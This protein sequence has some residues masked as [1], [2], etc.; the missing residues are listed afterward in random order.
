MDEV[1]VIEFATYDVTNVHSLAIVFMVVMTGLTIMPNRS[2]AAI[3]LVAVCLLMPMEQRVVVGGLDFSLL[4]IITIV[5]FLRILARGEFRGFAFGQLDRLFLMWVL[6]AS[7]F[8]LMRVGSSGFVFILGATFDALM[9][10]FVMRALVR[11]RGD[12]MLLWRNVAWVIIFLSPFIFYESITRRN[13]FGMFNY[14]GFDIAVVRNGKVRAT[15]P[16]SHPI[17]TGTLGSVVVPVFFGIFRAVKKQRVLM[18]AAC[19]AA[20]V[21]TL[22]AGSSGP[23]MAWG[24]GALGWMLWRIR[25][26]MRV[27]LLSIVFM[28]VV[29]HFIREQPV[30]H[31]LLRLSV[32]TGGTGYHRF[33]LIDAF[34]NNFSEWAIMGTDNTAHWG[35][36]LQDTTNQY[37][38]EGVNG[39]LITLVLFILM[40]RAC[41]REL[42][43][44]RIT[45]ERF[46]GPASPWALFAWGCSV[47]LAAHC[48]SFIS[49]T[50]F[51][52]FL[53]F[54]F[55]FVAT[56][57][58][59]ARFKRPKSAKEPV[60]PS[61]T[62]SPSPQPQ[63]APA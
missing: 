63:P 17:L 47:S 44:A 37:V 10:Y 5:A 13:V 20:T 27:I 23:V 39:G 6:S 33:H 62:P 32:I 50:Y 55:F 21:I 16:L 25:K 2:R 52:Q 31:L 42:R 30:W 38:A 61:P 53:Q 19:V 45:Y 41:F 28:L 12:V 40:L 56:F 46:E 8:Y 26:R 43:S 51:G 58:A 15:G 4:R 54:F 3:A 29:I 9:S 18:A 57:P 7:A 34:I 1:R 35:W 22:G 49:V 59:F 14:E 60:Q 48:V 36:G 11:S 24:V